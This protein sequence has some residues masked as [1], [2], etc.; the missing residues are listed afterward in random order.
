MKNLQGTKEKVL[1][2]AELI[3]IG[4]I[5]GSIV[6]YVMTRAYDCSLLRQHE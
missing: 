6:L 4:I 3:G 5:P 1:F 2:V